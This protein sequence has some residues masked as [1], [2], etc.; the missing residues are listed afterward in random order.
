LIGG[1]PDRVIFTSGATEAINLAIKG[2]ARA[3]ARKGRHI[4]VTQTEHKAVLDVCRS[5]ERDG[6]EI[7]YL[8]VNQAGIVDV[9]FLQ[10][11]IRNDT[12]LVGVIWANNETGVIQPIDEIA[13]VVRSKRCILFSDSTQAVGKIPVSAS[14]VDLL[15][16]SAHKFYGPKGVGALYLGGGR[17]VIRLTPQIDGGGQ[18]GGRRGGTLNTPGIVGLGMAAV[19]AAQELENEGRRLARLRDRLET[20][21][22]ERLEGTQVN[23]SRSSRL[24]GTTNIRFPGLSS[25]KLIPQLHELAISAGSACSSGSGRPSHVLK[26]LGLTDEEAGASIRIGLGRFTTEA[27]IDR[28]IDIVIE[29]IEAQWTLNPS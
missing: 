13:E 18:E 2:L 8:P 6:F 22:I 11:T 25:A 27:E 19:I 12:I 14:Q 21:I 26:A 3:H 28:A 20:T 1:E 5:L 17:P 15:T 23:G 7:T 10:E 4:V 16:F 24:S 9:S 29:K